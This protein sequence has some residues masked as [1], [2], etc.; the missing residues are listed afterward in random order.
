MKI[1]VVEDRK[2]IQDLICEI[3]ETVAVN[4]NTDPPE[5]PVIVVAQDGGEGLQQ[6]KAQEF[7]ILFADV[8]MPI[9][10]GIEMIRQAKNLGRAP[11][12]IFLVTA[13]ELEPE[14]LKELEVKEYFQKPLI[15]VEKMKCAI[16][17]LNL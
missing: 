4:R 1:L 17:S 10:N 13:Q 15:S 12:N 8:D 16:E 6:L 7:D 5:P 2:L 9:L 3:L 11:K 14:L